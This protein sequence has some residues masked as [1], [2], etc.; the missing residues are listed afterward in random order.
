LALRIMA[1]FFL[2]KSLFKTLKSSFISII[3]MI[4]LL[5]SFLSLIH[6]DQYFMRDILRD[7]FYSVN[8]ILY[9]LY[10]R[11]FFLSTQELKSSKFFQYLI[12]IY[13]F[14]QGVFLLLSYVLPNERAK[15]M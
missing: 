14:F 6:Y 3:F 5:G 8:P 4:I 7:F 12:I 15:M 9:F 13:T 10:G 1:C 2:R 11:M